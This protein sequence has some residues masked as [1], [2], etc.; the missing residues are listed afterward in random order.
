MTVK[1][2]ACNCKCY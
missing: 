2:P 1:I